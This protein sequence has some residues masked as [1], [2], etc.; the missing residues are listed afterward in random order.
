MYSWSECGQL[1]SH[2]NS[3]LCH[4]S[5]PPS[6]GTN[7][8][9]IVTNAILCIW[10]SGN[11]LP[12]VFFTFHSAATPSWV[13]QTEW[14]TQSCFGSW[15]RW[16]WEYYSNYASDE[17]STWCPEI[18]ISHWKD[19][20]HLLFRVISGSSQLVCCDVDTN[21]LWLWQLIRDVHCY[22]IKLI[23]F[24]TLICLLW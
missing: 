15:L 10:F 2:T 22:I 6:R 14:C 23:Y 5:T 20:T 9:V 19:V 4:I 13:R 3:S 17:W 7:L 8:W 21:T 11:K 24:S 12:D 1:Q 16:E 18:M